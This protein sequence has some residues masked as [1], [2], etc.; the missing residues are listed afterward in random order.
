[1]PEVIERQSQDGSVG[2][3]QIREAIT[4]FIASRDFVRK[5]VLVI[6]P[7]NTRSGPI[8]EVF[9]L[10]YEPLSDTATCVNR[11]LPIDPSLDFRQL[12][13][14]A[15]NEMMLVRVCAKFDPYFPSSGLAAQMKLDDKIDDTGGYALVT[16]SAFVNEP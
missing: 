2:V 8:G 16:T 12:E 6:I 3:D 1:M 4:E 11:A 10:L 5:R 13:G 14:G 7:D 15:S 9:K